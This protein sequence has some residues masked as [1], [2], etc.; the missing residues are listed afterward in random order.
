M[1]N[2][3]ITGVGIAGLVF[4]CSLALCHGAVYSRTYYG[5]GDTSGVGVVGLGSLN[6]A[7]NGTT[8]SGSFVSGYPYFQECVVIYI[9]ARAG[10]FAN[11]T[12][13]ADSVSAAT[14]AISGW[15]GMGGRATANFAAGFRADYAIVLSANY[16]GGLYELSSG[17]DWSLNLLR[18]INTFNNGGQY[19]FSI[20]W[21][22]IGITGDAARYLAFQS[23]Y[24]SQFGYRYL[25]SF[26]TLTGLKGFNTVNFDYYNTFGVE[27]VPEPVNIAL[28]V[29]GG[30]ALVAGLARGL[31]GHLPLPT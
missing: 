9:D 1:R 6:L 8:I 30:L 28:G 18:P 31:R 24:V 7:H 26:E 5:N 14:R 2:P 21:S 20:D 12:S 11:T 19:Q 23:S 13:F 10:G 29:F 4:A 17:G 22:D 3:Y 16:S 27:P 15:N 25:E